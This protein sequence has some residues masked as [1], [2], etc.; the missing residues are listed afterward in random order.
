M[1]REK[2]EELGTT[3]ALG[4]TSREVIAIITDMIISSTQTDLILSLNN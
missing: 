3:M 2:E 1:S 4:W